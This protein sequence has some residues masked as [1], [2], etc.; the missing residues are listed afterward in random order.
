MSCHG[1]KK[2]AHLNGEIDD[3]RDIDMKKKEDG[4]KYFDIDIDRCVVHFED[5]NLA[6][7][8]VPVKVKTTNLCVV[9]DFAKSRRRLDLYE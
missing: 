8:P 3:V 2:A 5:K 7:V 4:S 1:L 6:P 9:F